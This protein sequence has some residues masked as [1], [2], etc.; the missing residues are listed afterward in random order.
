[1]G[2]GPSDYPN[3]KCAMLYSSA[4]DLTMKAYAVLY[5]NVN[6]V[7]YVS[8]TPLTKKCSHMHVCFGNLLFSQVFI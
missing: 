8:V 1:M 6:T 4:I 2:G 7:N 3:Y 5:N